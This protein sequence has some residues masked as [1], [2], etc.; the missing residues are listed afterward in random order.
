MYQI[1]ICDDEVDCANGIAKILE[2]QFNKKSFKASIK[3]ITDRQE[4]IYNAIKN[5]EIDILFLDIDFKDTGKNGIDFAS[6]LRK[7]NKNFYL[8]FLTA[9][10][11]YLHISLVCKTYD[12]LVKPISKNVI[13]S[14]IDRLIDEFSINNKK[15]VHL[16]KSLVIKIQSIIYI[17]KIGSKSYIYTLS[18]TYSCTITLDS[19]LDE[20]PNHFI[21]CHRSYIVNK[22]FISTVDHKKKSIIF[23][24]G[25]KCP[26]NSHFKL[27]E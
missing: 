8:I 23:E 22:E 25:L 4:I 26:I 27:E 3:I 11:R 2:T 5:N 1:A 9:H 24:N 7:I 16:N 20:L 17:E 19:L 6:D 14:F 21:K 10:L 18:D 12:F 13:D 15:F